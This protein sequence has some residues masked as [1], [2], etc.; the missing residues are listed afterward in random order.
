MKN[1]AKS[2][3]L[4]ASKEI[5]DLI[6]FIKASPTSW[7]AGA[8]A[9]HLCVDMNGYTELK[10]NETWEIVP[11]GKYFVSRDIS[12][13]IAFVM[14][15]FKPKS[16]CIL[17]AHT[18]SPGLKLKPNP[19][20][21]V[22]NTS[23]LCPEVYGGPILPS[24][25]GQNLGL[26]GRITYLDEKNN[27]KSSLVDFEKTVGIIPFL[28]IHLDRTQKE[29]VEL[30]PQDHLPAV[31]NLQ[32]DDEPPFQFEEELKKLVPFS[33]LLSHEL[34]FVP[35]DPPEIVNGQLLHSP[36]LD[37][38]LGTHAALYALLDSQ[39]PEES[40]IKTVICWDHEE[41]GSNTYNGASS[42][43][44]DSVLERICN[45]SGL[46]REE[47][48]VLK[49]NSGLIS[50]DAAHGRHPNYVGKYEP[51]NSPLLGKGPVIKYNANQSYASNS[52]SAAWIQQAGHECGIPIQEFCI[53]TD[54]TCGSTIGNIAA[55]RLGI[56]TVDIGAPIWGMHAMKE[57]GSLLDHLYMCRLLKKVLS[58]QL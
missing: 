17:G 54:T 4:Q 23:M 49:A 57:T 12:T 11:G 30:N 47:F 55:P 18:D 9:R 21:Q 40:Q 42:N 39:Q 37:N 25:V 45:S 1:I 32:T 46:N 53:K 5:K 15:H 28:A 6:E 20:K 41:I 56:T 58:M 31:C 43:F 51:G 10:E 22:D 36:R 48:A 14:P 7:H 24:W 13:F 19:N 50:I 44:L 35:R 34:H 26:A 33:K 38:L 2:S 52:P 3:N 16:A 29:K 27:R 8:A